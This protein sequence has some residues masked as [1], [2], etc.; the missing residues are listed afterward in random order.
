VL[1][2]SALILIANVEDLLLGGY[3]VKTVFS[4]RDD[5]LKSVRAMMSVLRERGIQEENIPDYLKERVQWV[6]WSW[7]VRENG[8]GDFVTTKV[9]INVETGKMASHSDPSTWS[10]FENALQK[11][12]NS[13]ETS[14]VGY[15]ISKDDDV[16]GID[17]DNCI[18]AQKNIHPE[19]LELLNPYE[20]YIEASPSMTGVKL[21]GYGEID[22]SQLNTQAGSGFKIHNYPLDSMDIE[23]YQHSRFFTITSMKLKSKP[24]SMC[25]IQDLVDTLLKMKNGDTHETDGFQS[26]I[27]NAVIEDYDSEIGD[28]SESGKA[29][30]AETTDVAMDITENSNSDSEGDSEIESEENYQENLHEDSSSVSDEDLSTSP[31]PPRSYNGVKPNNM[32]AN[33]VVDRILNSKQA[34]IF[35]TLYE[36]DIS[37][38][39]SQ[40]EA[41]LALTSILCW[42]CQGDRMK[43]E[44]IFSSSKLVR[45]KWSNRQDYRDGLWDTV[46]SGQYYMPAELRDPKDLPPIFSIERRIDIVLRIVNEPDVFEN[47]ASNIRYDCHRVVMDYELKDGDVITGVLFSDVI[48]HELGMRSISNWD[49]DKSGKFHKGDIPNWIKINNMLSEYVPDTNWGSLTNRHKSAASKLDSKLDETPSDDVGF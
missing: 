18:D 3:I 28:G 2:A 6:L 20:C 47:K 21:L 33:E 9:P 39:P 42:W 8:K 41:D 49:R 27:N 1:I 4:S 46:D 29:V 11:F 12:G 38:Y 17:V 26:E 24:S 15:V 34:A 16:I 22:V 7:Q 40:S 45:D 30:D 43:A 25:S 48:C 14:G 13:T 35:R 31:E 19:V 37:N 44:Q 32:T 5:A 23:V 36:G 10:S